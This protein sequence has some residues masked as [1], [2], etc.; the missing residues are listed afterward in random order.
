MEGKHRGGDIVRI[1]GV[2]A[3]RLEIDHTGS[4]KKLTGEQE[5]GRRWQFSGYEI[6]R[7]IGITRE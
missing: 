7:E 4:K 3:L 6:K 5:D 2:G 1:T